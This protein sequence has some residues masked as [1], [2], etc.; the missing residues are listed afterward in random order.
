M[1]ANKRELPGWLGTTRVSTGPTQFSRLVAAKG[2]F[3]LLGPFGTPT[4]GA[5]PW[6]IGRGGFRRGGGGYARNPA[7]LRAVRH[8]EYAM[9]RAEAERQEKLA[10]DYAARGDFDR[11]D[12]AAAAAQRARR[13]LAGRGFVSTKR[14]PNWFQPRVREGWGYPPPRVSDEGDEGDAKLPWK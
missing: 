1:E 5:L 6:E 7:T 10:E 4:P 13:Q 2:A 14:A 3:G 12:E 8:G 11:A 9:R